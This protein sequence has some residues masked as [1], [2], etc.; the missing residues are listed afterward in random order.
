MS[1]KYRVKKLEQKSSIGE[2]PVTKIVVHYIDMEGKVSGTTIKKL[3]DG[4][5][6]KRTELTKSTN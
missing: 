6:C 2:N 3:I 1:L 5:W 4:V